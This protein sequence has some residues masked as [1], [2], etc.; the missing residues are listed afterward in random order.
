MEVC[1]LGKDSGQHRWTV[2][3]L[4]VF[5]Q[6][7]EVNTDM[8]NYYSNNGFAYPPYDVQ[9]PAPAST[10]MEEVFLPPTPQREEEPQ[11]PFEHKANSSPCPS[12]RGPAYEME[13]YYPVPELE[14]ASN[15]NYNSSST[16]EEQP[17]I[18]VMRTKGPIDGANIYHCVGI[19]CALLSFILTPLVEVIPMFLWCCLNQDLRHQTRNNIPLHVIN[20]GLTLL[21]FL[22]W[23]FAI[24]LLGV[25][26]WGVFFAIFILMIPTAVV[27]IELWISQPTFDDPSLGAKDATEEI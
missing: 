12:P 16:P 8:S 21:L 14:D 18:K 22:A 4:P 5:L 27:L 6:A 17:M 13:P 7:T 19:M 11:G 9:P 24:V 15:P 23:T 25:L 26:S 2:D 3:R 10:G 1:Y 20:F